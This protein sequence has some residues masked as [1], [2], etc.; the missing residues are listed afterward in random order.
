[1]TFKDHGY[2]GYAYIGARLT[3]AVVLLPVIGM[4]GNFIA[5]ITKSK[6]SPPSELVTILVFVRSPSQTCS[7][8][9]PTNHL[10]RLPSLS[11]GSSSP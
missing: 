4:A 6:H 8:E 1:M 2:Y 11:S 7:P 10:N 3:Q 5:L 9:P